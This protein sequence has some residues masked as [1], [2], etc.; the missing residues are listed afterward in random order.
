MRTKEKKAE[1]TTDLL[2]LLSSKT[3]FKILTLLMYSDQEVCVKE[4]AEAIGASHSA[5]SH[6]LARLED[7]GIVTSVRDGQTVCYY[8]TSSANVKKLRNIIKECE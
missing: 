3:R 7:R 2:R 6:Q 5:T 8:L 1:R 4:I